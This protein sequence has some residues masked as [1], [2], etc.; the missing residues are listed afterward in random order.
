MISLDTLAAHAGRD[1][2]EALGVHAPPLDLSSTYPLPH[3][4]LDALSLESLAA[5]GP[6]LGNSVYARLHNPTVARFERGLAALEGAP[7]AVAFA[8]GMAALTACLLA[9]RERGDHVLAVRP[10]YGGSD[11]LL[12]SGLLGMRT[13]FVDVAGIARAVRAETALVILETPANPTLDLVDIARVV[14]DARGVP[15]LVDSTF[16]T[17][18][19]QRPLRHGAALVLHS[20]T[21]YLGGHGDVLG[22]AVATDAAWA[23]ALRRVRVATGAVLHPLAGYLLHR[24]LQTLPLRVRASQAGARVLA[25]RLLTHPAVR[26]VFY[27]EL[28]GGDPLGLVGRQMA[29]GGGILS[30]TVAGAAA[31][32]RVLGQVRL[33]TPAVSLGSCDTLLQVPAAFTHRLVDAAVR[34]ATAIEPGLLRMSVGVEDP[35]DL[36]ADLTQALDAAEVV[37]SDVRRRAVMAAAS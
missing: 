7:E 24:G 11:H 22:G 37:D 1:D 3:P 16:A 17:P 15:V 34:E 12:A 30:F 36:W 2:L 23:A 33:I 9:A 26:R 19:L 6:P 29:G 25:R 27:P 5:G 13:D 18:V 31:A 32:M 14:A 4:D 20:A 8:S 28:P 21:K 10:L 35:E